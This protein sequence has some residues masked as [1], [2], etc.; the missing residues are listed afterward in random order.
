[1]RNVGKDIVDALHFNAPCGCTGLTE[2]GCRFTFKKRPKGGRQLMPDA[3]GGM[4]CEAIY[5][6]YHAAMD[7]YPYQAILYRL[8]QEFR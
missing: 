1:M 4:Y 8:Y 3:S 7:W 5:S 6:E 2:K